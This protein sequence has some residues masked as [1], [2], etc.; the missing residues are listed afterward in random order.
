MR[1]DLPT[2]SMDKIA[3]EAGVSRITLYREF[4]NKASLF[5]AVVAYRLLQ[6][7]E[8]FFH[9]RRPGG[10]LGDLIEDYVVASSR[11]AHRNA[12]TRRWVDAGTRL[13][14]PGSAV[15]EVSMA[16][17]APWLAHF[18]RG[19]ALSREHISAVVTWINYLQYLFSRAVAD[20]K[21]AEPSL[22]ALLR[23]FV[24]PAFRGEPAGPQAVSLSRRS[25][26]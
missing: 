10:D 22:R 19:E 8:K 14:R 13:L 3:E 18:N 9:R 21:L 6:F 4:R 17:W 16:T 20:T 26:N 5:D 1:E 12:I 11:M 25:P 15:H 2:A 23:T 24:A 7:D